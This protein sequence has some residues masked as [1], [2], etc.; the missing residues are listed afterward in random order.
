MK[1]LKPIPKF[2]TV[3]EE[4][5]FWD[6]H[7]STE[8]IDW[9]SAV[10]VR[11]PNLRFTHPKRIQRKRTGGWRI[12]GGTVYVGRPSKWGNPIKIGVMNTLP[13]SFMYVVKNNDEAV[14]AY[15]EWIYEDQRDEFREEIRN[16]LK[17]RNLCCWCPLD[18]I[19]HADILLRIANKEKG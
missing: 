12:P 19:C 5:D 1:K 13:Q 2:K 11:F 17:G 16:E 9:R 3:E 4:V 18:K 10:R 15:T 14:R 8:Y 7:D 6:T